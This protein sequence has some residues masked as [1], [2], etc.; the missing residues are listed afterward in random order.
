[1]RKTYTFVIALFLVALA[2]NVFSQDLDDLMDAETKT[3]VNY[4]S[5]TFKAS[6]I[7]NGHSIEQMKEKQLDFRIS[8]RFGTLNDGAYGLFGLDQSV[9]HFS[10]EYGLKDWLMLGAGRA[11]MNKTYD[12]PNKAMTILKTHHF[13]TD[14]T[15][16]YSK[17]SPIL[18]PIESFF[19]N[20]R[21]LLPIPQTEID[22]NN[23]IVIKN[24]PSY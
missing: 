23:E 19:I 14:W 4:T 17:Y 1:M 8:H 13:V 12:D 20:D 18:P 24:N 22:T 15:L 2:G 5:A 3:G 9:I 10:L 11:S 7:I 21:L 6:R 16:L